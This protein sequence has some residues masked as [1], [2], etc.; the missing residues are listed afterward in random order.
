MITFSLHTALCHSMM[1]VSYMCRCVLIH[2]TLQ[3]LSPLNTTRAD[4]CLSVPFLQDLGSVPLRDTKI[5]PDNTEESSMP[6]PQ[7]NMSKSRIPYNS[8]FRTPLPT[9][10]DTSIT[11]PNVWY[12]LINTAQETTNTD[13]C[14]RFLCKKTLHTWLGIQS[15]PSTTVS[16]IPST[17]R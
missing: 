7:M 5:F 14:K 8:Y 1:H 16:L 2:I 13:G 4:P 17:P 10:S 3:C 6:K 11:S 15:V 12:R 9:I